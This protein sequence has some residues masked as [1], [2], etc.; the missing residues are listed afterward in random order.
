MPLPAQQVFSREFDADFFRLPDAIQNL[1][2]AKID[3]LATRLATH[4]HQ[5][6]QGNANFRLRV[7]DYRIIY[8]FDLGAGI[9]FLKLVGHRREVYRWR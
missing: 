9:L 4:P 1:I 8:D 5:R 2:E 3:D 7:G 6:L